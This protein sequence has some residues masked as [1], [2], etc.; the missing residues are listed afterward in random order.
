MSEMSKKEKKNK[1]RNVLCVVES[2]W[3]QMGCSSLPG[4]V[5]EGCA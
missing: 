4:F 5:M 3:F 2:L 1:K